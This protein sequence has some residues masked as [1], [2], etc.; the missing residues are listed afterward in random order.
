IKQSMLD[1]KSYKFILSMNT[2]YAIDPVLLQELLKGY[3]YVALK[4][5]KRSLAQWVYEVK[6][7]KFQYPKAILLNPNEKREQANLSGEY[8]YEVSESNTLEIASSNGILWYPKIVF[9]DS[10][11]RILE[12]SSQEV[13][14]VQ[15]IKIKIPKGTVFIKISDIYLPLTIK[16]GLI[17]E[18]RN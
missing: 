15:A 1:N 5:E 6:E 4:I 9:F 3:G 13:K 8:W 18:L 10:H 16:N 2:E 17:V 12:I 11:L 14:A 7:N